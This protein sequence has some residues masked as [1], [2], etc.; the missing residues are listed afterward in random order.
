[1][2]RWNQS[3]TG[4][5]GLPVADSHQRRQRGV[6]VA[7]RGDRLALPPVLVLQR[8][9]QQGMRLLGHA[10]HEREASGGLSLSLDLAAD[11]LE[12]PNLMTGHGTYVGPVEHDDGPARVR[13]CGLGRI[14][15]DSRDLGCCL[16]VGRL[17]LQGD[18]MSTDAQA[19]MVRR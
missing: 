13:R 2:E 8:R 3:R 14:V 17:K 4:S 5:T 1:M 10:A 18:G 15:S 7:D 16:S 19:L 11:R 12:V 9:A 6:A